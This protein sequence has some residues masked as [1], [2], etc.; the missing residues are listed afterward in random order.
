MRYH[1]GEE[2]VRV[3]APPQ[4]ETDFEFCGAKAQRPQTEV[5]REAK[6]GRSTF[7]CPLLLVR[8]GWAQE[9]LHAFRETGD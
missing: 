2:T 7:P 4:E 3:A 5:L 6:E 9:C 1:D 8:C